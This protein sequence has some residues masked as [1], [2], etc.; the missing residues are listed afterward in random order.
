MAGFPRPRVAEG[1][2]GKTIMIRM[3]ATLVTA[4]SDKELAAGTFKGSW[5]TIR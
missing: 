4:Y 5:G 1:D 2:W 3:D